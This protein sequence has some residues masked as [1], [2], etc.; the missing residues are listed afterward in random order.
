MST[1]DFPIALPS[2]H[3]LHEFRI[4]RV[5]GHGGFGITYLADDTTLRK[6]VA[7]KEY[8]PAQFAVRAAGATVMPRTR[9]LADDYR[10]G[11]ERFLD[12]ARIL[13]RFRH[14]NIVP[15][16]RFFEAHGTAYIVM[17]YEAGRPLAALL[18]G[19]GRLPPARVQALLEGLMDGLAQIHA[20]GFL[21][22]D[23]KPSN[24]IVLADG[25]PV[26]IDFGAARQAL[27]RGDVTLTSVVTPR[28]APLEQYQA[29]AE[30]GPWT[31]IY[32]LAAVAYHAVTGEAP[33][34]AP[35]RV[36]NDA[37]RKL[38]DAS[39]A[40]HAAPF[41]AA[42]DH[43]LAVHAEDR[44]RTIAVWRA[45]MGLAPARGARLDSVAEATPSAA[46]TRLMQEALTGVN[47]P[48]LAGPGTPRLTAAPASD[49]ERTVSSAPRLG[50]VDISLRV[51]SASASTAP[52]PARGRALAAS[53]VVVLLGAAA[54]FAWQTRGPTATD[55]RAAG[56]PAAAAPV[57]ASAPPASGEPTTSPTPGT[58][59]GGPSS[60]SRGADTTASPTKPRAAGAP[61]S[62]AVPP[63]ASGTSTAP[64]PIMRGV[65]AKGD[66][67]PIRPSAAGGSTGTVSSIDELLDRTDATSAP[68]VSPSVQAMRD[69]VLDSTRQAS[70]QAQ[71]AAEQARRARQLAT[72]RAGEA[73]IR[74]AEAA[75]ADLSGSERVTF[76][77]GGSYVG[78][79][80]DGRRGGLGVADL[81]SGER[82]AGDW[83]DDRLDGLGVLRASDGRSF[84]GDWREGLP[85]GVGVFRLGS[86]D[87]HFGQVKGGQPHGPGV[88]VTGEGGESVTRAGTWRHGALDGPGVES[89]ASGW[90]YEGGFRTGKR[91]GAGTLIGPDGLRF[92]GT[93]VDG[94]ADGYGVA[95]ASDGGVSSGEWRAGT[96]VRRDE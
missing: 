13:A 93:F 96:L 18:A 9:R 43:G 67:V 51:R 92:H 94:V 10:W 5:L 26:L 42:I 60:P 95:V 72:E 69:R 89:T 37:C 36:R 6:K 63:A 58:R 25:A 90:R 78:Q 65:E 81:A 35:A 22:R 59:P 45:S 32:A 91:H 23:I 83:R 11:L 74:A 20:A 14:P 49:A 64:P 80:A 12:E 50:G 31:D 41:L 87:R 19:P 56:A 66:P 39:I 15:V 21:H 71:A 55:P 47:P 79:L 54:V 4:E 44:P 3:A 57:V 1:P 62:V 2:R 30:Q 48:R 85:E 16:L 29:D 82:Q 24:I 75:M 77:G 68:S 86:Q 84:E 88:R 33:P 61:P 70:A 34:E 38:A 46:R 52:R 7:I 40:G 73:R 28:Y 8:L 17:E 76:E 53:V 27:R